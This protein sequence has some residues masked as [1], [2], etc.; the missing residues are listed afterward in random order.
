MARTGRP[1]IPIDQKSFEK[2]CEMQCSLEEIA[3]FF[4]LQRRHS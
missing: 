4:R 2:L 1:K 3:G